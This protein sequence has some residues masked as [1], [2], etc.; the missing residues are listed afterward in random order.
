MGTYVRAQSHFVFDQPT[1]SKPGQISQKG[2]TSKDY[3]S[4]LMEWL[5]S[6]TFTPKYTN[7]FHKQ[8]QV[9]LY[10]QNNKSQNQ[11]QKV[12]TKNNQQMN[13]IEQQLIE[14]KTMKT[15]INLSTQSNPN[16]SLTETMGTERITAGRSFRSLSTEKR[17]PKSISQKYPPT[18]HFTLQ[19]K[20]MYSEET[21]AGRIYRQQ[22]T[23]MDSQTIK[24]SITLAMKAI[25]SKR[26]IIEPEDNKTI[27]DPTTKQN[28]NK[29]VEI[30]NQEKLD[31]LIQPIPNKNQEIKIFYNPKTYYP[32]SPHLLNQA[33]QKGKLQYLNKGYNQPTTMI[34][35]VKQVN[36]SP[37]PISPQGVP[38]L[39]LTTTLQTTSYSS[40]SGEKRQMQ[41]QLLKTSPQTA[42][43]A[44]IPVQDLRNRNKNPA[45][46]I[47]QKQSPI[48]RPTSRNSWTDQG[49]KEER[50]EG[51]DLENF[52]TDK[53]KREI[54]DRNRKID[55]EILGT[56]GN[57]QHERFHPIRIYPLKERQLEYQE[58]IMSD[59]D[60]EIQGTR[61]RSEIL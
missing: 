35:E 24:Q 13:Q 25:T 22:P 18:L 53:E 2:H 30:I 20:Q 31:H 46:R 55:S 57:Y 61:R 43:K 40:R 11:K 23:K 28:M 8:Q 44:S 19:T 14:Q 56:M 36:Q 34:L 38:K 33:K 41:P 39:E 7:P 45:L 48:P 27:K 1:T 10:S 52:D 29:I 9:Q 4:A 47:R 51:R 50:G 15:M 42:P 60:N 49:R 21:V 32:Q 37:Y 16:I 12:K 5:D 59:K 26:M 3:Q 6:L 17:I 54:S 58:A